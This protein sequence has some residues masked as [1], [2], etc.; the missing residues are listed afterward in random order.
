MVQQILADITS[1]PK[2]LSKYILFK[3]LGFN[4]ILAGYDLDNKCN[5]NLQKGFNCS[6]HP[7]D[8][9]EGPFEVHLQRSSQNVNFSFP[10]D[11]IQI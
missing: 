1:A 2:Q 4:R 10:T 11:L 5:R 8:K 9:Y 7:Q 3:S 6:I